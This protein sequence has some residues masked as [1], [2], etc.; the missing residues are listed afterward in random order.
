MATDP[1]MEALNVLKAAF[2]KDK[3][4][5]EKEKE[6]DKEER[7]KEKEKAKEE[8]K[9]RD[10]EFALLK[11]DVALLKWKTDCRPIE[12]EIMRV[13]RKNICESLRHA[14]KDSKTNRSFDEQVGMVIRKE[15]PY[16]NVKVLKEWEKWRNNM[17]LEDEVF[18]RFV[19]QLHTLVE[20]RNDLH[21]SAES[22]FKQLIKTKGP[23]YT[24]YKSLGG[25][26]R[27]W[28]AVRLV[29]ASASSS[30]SSASDKD[31]AAGVSAVPMDM[32]DETIHRTFIQICRINDPSLIYR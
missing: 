2:E 1:V 20:V 19:F 11:Q 14:A 3:E 4:E 23:G 27:I 7:E 32:E 16:N 9:E 29:S 25:D 31:K 15:I 6:K 13:L 26:E 18:K 24:F 10:E 12:L 17:N 5:R 30:G 22:A 28:D 21:V 8:Q